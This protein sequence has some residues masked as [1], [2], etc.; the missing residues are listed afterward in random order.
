MNFLARLFM[1]PDSFA[2]DPWGFVKN[3]IGHAVIG[4]G[5][6]WLMGP[7]A[8]LAIYAAW[9]TA[10]WLLRSA[11]PWDCCED[12]SFAFAGALATV[13]PLVLSPSGLH[14]LAGYLRR[15]SSG[16]E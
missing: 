12:A 16:E 10:Q 11:D 2:N 14:M 3:Q 15:R 5:L 8:A 9:E 6:A 7:L 13:A 4:A 1:T